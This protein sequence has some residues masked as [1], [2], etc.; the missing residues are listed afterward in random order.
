MSRKPYYVLIGSEEGRWQDVM[1]AALGSEKQVEMVSPNKL[2]TITEQPTLYIIDATYVPDVQSVIQTLRKRCHSA[3]ILVV[4]SM[5]TWTRARDALKAGAIDYVK[6]S[7]D[8]TVIQ[9][10]IEAALKKMLPP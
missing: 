7:L 8:T 6:K 3:R 4:A 9:E 1:R 2:D 5:P 10:T